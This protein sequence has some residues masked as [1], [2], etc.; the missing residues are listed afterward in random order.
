[1]IREVDFLL[2]GGGPASAIAAET[3]RAEGAKGSIVMIAAEHALPYFRPS[4][5]K[6]FLLGQQG[7]DRLDIF[8]AAEYQRQQIE[9]LKGV[10]ALA[11]DP[12]DRI[13]HTD[14]AGTIRYGK[15]L[16]ATGS[17]PRRLE[18][19]GAD[20]AGSYCLRTVADAEA[21]RGAA[22]RAKHAV[23]VGG[24]FIGMEL[25]SSLSRIGLAV[26]LIVRARTLF[27]MLPAPAISE[28]FLKYFQRCG[29]EVLLEDA[30]CEFQGEDRVERV[31][32]LSGRSIPCDLAA[33]GIGVDPET[34]FLHGSGVT[35]EDGIHVDHYMQ[36]N[37]PH[38]FAA[39]D[40]ASFI[41][42][43]F[44][45]RRRIE[46]WDNAVKQ[47][48]LAAKNMLG[49]RQPHEGISYFFS[50]VFDFTFEFFGS[51][52][53]IDELIERGSPEE[54]SFALFCLKD[55]VP[56]AIFSVGRPAVETKAA[57]SLIS[58]RVNL[59]AF[60]DRLA[61]RDFP[62]EKIP[63]QTVLVLQGGGA[64]GAFECGVVKALDEFLIVPDV[65]AG[66]SIGAFNGAIIASNPKH[67]SSALESFW[68]DLAL[69]TP[70]IPDEGL[71][72]ALSAWHAVI[73]GSPKFFRP[74]WLMPPWRPADLPANWTSFYD[75]SPVKEL[76]R[77]YVDFPALKKSPVRLLISAV[78]VETAELVTF[79]SRYDELTPDHI[80]ASGSLPPGFPWTIIDNKSY[81]DGGIVSNSPL[82]QVIERC[83]ATN[84]RVFI[85]DLY[86]NMS[87][88]PKSL[89]GVM[90]RRDEI[91]YSERLN[92]DVRTGELI[93]DFRGLIN[94]ML[95]SMDPM[96]AGQI[97]QRPRYIKL[98]GD[99]SP[100]T[101]TRIIHDDKDGGLASKDFDFSVKTVE[102]HKRAGYQMARKELEK[103]EVSSEHGEK[104][105]QPRLAMR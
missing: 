35:V 27:D 70:Q 88:L 24:N 60:K 81:W 39:G 58:N 94:E 15:L 78:D 43:V 65:V 68:K 84:K 104:P 9:V 11:L 91:A 42:P 37:Q 8:P 7:R 49:Q 44:E 5:S 90:A 46:H 4:L 55:N 86:P 45:I 36:T 14:F 20:L 10:R 26:T 59:E 50:D 47:G 32:T 13:L 40:V 57:E 16:I 41:D 51:T 54:K 76:L 99:L 18:V 66:V 80:V 29:V 21:I 38:V 61:D 34:E 79:D 28:F 93:R 73:F 75:T 2:V 74:R 87:P 53:G 33:L 23:V 95:S 83:G 100:M 97:R 48:R 96:A 102:A 67:A 22:K 89:M 85:I 30:V 92:K 56:R 69:N 1:M 101:I 105:A 17:R 98:M 52:E 77:K 12:G 6:Q 3:L 19:P 64:L 103:I 62:L 72:Q 71:R 31:A 25:A 82:D 63:A